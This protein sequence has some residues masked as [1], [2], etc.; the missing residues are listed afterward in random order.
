MKRI[1]AFVL[2]IIMVFS[3]MPVEAYAQNGETDQIAAEE[4]VF[5][6]EETQDELISIESQ[7]VP[8][9]EIQENSSEELQETLPENMEDGLPE[10]EQEIMPEEKQENVIEKTENYVENESTLAVSESG[11]C[12]ENAYWS[13]S[14]SGVLSIT[15]SG[16]MKDYSESSTAPWFSERLNIKR[17]EISDGITYVGDY[18]FYY[19]VNMKSVEIPGTVKTVGDYAFYKCTAL[20]IATVPEGVTELYAYVFNGCVSLSSVSLPPT[21]TYIGGYTFGGCVSLEDPTIPDSVKSMGSGVFSGCKKLKIM[22]LPESMTYLSDS[23]FNGC[24]S[25]EHVEIPDRVTAIGSSAFAGC[26]SLK[27]IDIPDGVTSI[28]GYAFENCTAL[29]EVNLPEGLSRINYGC[30]RGCTGLKEIEIPKG[31]VEIEEYA[32]Y[33]CSSLNKVTL[34]KGLVTIGNYAFEWCESLSEV[35]IPE[36]VVSIG[37]QCFAECYALESVSIPDTV[38]FLGYEIFCNCISLKSVNLTAG[39]TLLGQEMFEGCSALESISIPNTVTSF[40]TGT[41]SYCTSL[42][43]VNIPDKIT[44]IGANVFYECSAL[45]IIEIPDGVTSM[46]NGV[47]CGCSALKVIDIPGTVTSIGYDAFHDC[48]SLTEVTLPEGLTSI[49]AEL[50][51]GCDNLTKVQIPS[52]VTTIGEY[53]FGYCPKLTDITFNHTS[54]D[55]L[56]IHANAFYLSTYN[57]YDD[58]ATTI[59]VP[60]AR[61]IHSAIQNYEWDGYGRSEKFHSFGNAPAMKIKIDENHP[62]SVEAGLEVQFTATLEPKNTTSD[63][64]WEV[65]NV[66]GKAQ[67][68]QNGV[69]IGTTPGIVTVICKS[70]DNSAIY[71]DTQ[72]TILKATA[73]VSSIQVRC[74]GEFEAE[75]ELGDSVQMI[76]DVQPGNAMNKKIRW[77]IENGTGEA[78]ITDKGV[79]TGKSCGTVTVYAIAQDGSEVI[80]SRVVEVMRYVEEVKVELNGR[81]DFVQLGVAETAKMTCI[82]LPEDANYPKGEVYIENGT[83]ENGTGEATYY[84]GYLTGVAPGEVT[85]KVIAKDSH[86]CS[87]EKEIEIVGEKASYAVA[88]GYIYYNTETGTIIDCDEKVTSANIPAIINGT[89]ITGIAPQAFYS[90]DYLTSVTI[91]SSVTTIGDRAFYDCD[92]IASLRFNGSGVKLI[93]DYAFYDCDSLV[94]LTIPEGVETIG[95]CAFEY[96]SGL[97]NLTIPEGITS[98]E[99]YAF[100]G[101]NNLKNLTI[102]GDYNTEEWLGCDVLDTV[103]F[104]GTRIHESIVYDHGNGGYSWTVLPGR[105]AKKVIISD[106]VT[107]IGDHA[108]R[109]V[110]YIEEAVIGD[111]VK[112]IGEY[113]FSDCYE[114]MKVTMG[115][116]VETIGESAFWDCNSLTEIEIGNSVKSIGNEAFYRCENLTKVT[117]PEGI[118]T[119][120]ES[121]F[122]ECEKLESINLPS[123]LKSVGR[124]CFEFTSDKLQLIDLSMN[125]T[126]MSGQELK[127][128]YSMPKALITSAGQ[129]NE[130]WWDLRYTE[131]DMEAGKPHPW[132]IAGLD[133]KSGM[134]YAHGSRVGIV[135]VECR[136]EYTGA[137]GTW[138]IEFS[139]GITIRTDREENYLVSG[140]TMQLSAYIMPGNIK[141]NVRWSLRE[142]DKDYASIDSRTG[143][144]SARAVNGAKQIEVTAIPNDDSEPVS[145]ELWIVPKTTGLYIYEGTGDVTDQE[146]N[147][148]SSVFPVLEFTSVAYPEGALTEV[149]WRSSN[150][151]IASV[152]NGLVT[153][154]GLGTVTITVYAADG[155]GK[156]ASV[157]LNVTFRDMA[158]KLTA[159]LDVEST[160]LKAGDQAQML[161]Y[162]D[163]ADVPMDPAMFEYGI[164]TSQQSIATVD[165]D[166]VITAGEKAGTATITATMKDDP[167]GRKVSIKITV[168]ARLTEKLLLHPEEK[169]PAQIQM[170][171]ENGNVTLDASDVVSYSVLL[172]KADLNDGAYTFVITPEAFNSAGSFQPEKA[173]LKW[174]ST[175]TKVAT[176][177]AQKDGT[178]IVTIKQGVDGACM[179]SAVTT[180]KAKVENRLTVNV[181]D[182]SPRL[183]NLKPVLNTYLSK[184]VELQL[185]PSYENWIT[186]VELYENGVVSSRL[187]AVYEDGVVTISSKEVIPNS[188]IAPVLKVTCADG[189]TYDYKLAAKVKNT[190]PSV[191]VKQLDKMNLFYTDSEVPVK[192]TAADIAVTNV[193]LEGTEDFTVIEY[194]AD[195]AEAL[196][197]FSDS[198][199]FEHNVKPDTKAD[200]LV[201]LEGYEQ[202]VKKAITIA[203]TTKKPDVVLTEKSSVINTAMSSD[204]VTSFGFQLKNS[205]ELL[206]L[207]HAQPP[208][209]TAN[210]AESMVQEN[211]VVLRLTGTKGGTAT[212]ELQLDNWMS[213][214]KFSHKVT[215]DTKAPTLKFSASALKLSSVFTD[216][217]DSTASLLTHSN[218]EINRIDFVSTAKEG[219]AA[220][221]QS[222]KLR[223]AHDPDTNQIIARILDPED[224]PKNGSYVFEAVATLTDG[225]VLKAA[226]LKVTVDAAA[227]KVKLA[228][229]TLKLNKVLFGDEIASTKVSLDKPEGYKLI[230][231][232]LPDNW[233]EQSI[234]VEIDFAEDQLMVKLLDA[235]AAIKTHTIK[236]NPILIDESTGQEVVIPTAVSLRVQV[237][238]NE[239]IS[240]SLSSKGKLDVVDPNSEIRYTVSKINNASGPVT[241]VYLDGPDADLFD[242][243]FNENGTVSLKLVSGVDYSIKQT[244]K[245]QFVFSI[246]GVEV[247]S[248]VVSFKVTQSALKLNMTPAKC[249]LYQSQTTPLTLRV[250]LTDPETAT[251]ETITLG[252]KSSQEFVNALGADPM[253]VTIAEDGR[254]AIV[255]FDIRNAAN[256]QFGKSYVI[257]LDVTAVGSATDGKVNQMKVTINVAK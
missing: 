21:L 80:G 102:P 112:S 34:P 155:S 1:I 31:V 19:C 140:E 174:A 117:L 36:G 65:K 193:E 81:E 120:G 239:K 122:R 187:D 138:D 4:N 177:A 167:L 25:L 190:A 125:P 46:G 158:K 7:K 216:K 53:A 49:S 152:D 252:E 233:D 106:T 14:D 44:S 236:L 71:D 17:V 58:V 227:P 77:E 121:A 98:I 240:V 8:V 89:K 160:T 213:S 146:L 229:S 223:V 198:C 203:T 114:L 73:T 92:K 222:D 64:I 29:P 134:L 211:R 128:K 40:G 63:L 22:D 231:F 148:D 39:I 9:E 86:Q 76:A 3:V 83:D 209:V 159:A 201:Y 245:V 135:T 141:T 79:L 241:G 235:E 224:A 226:K 246:C 168:E 131:E 6:E 247:S 212:V 56:E 127:L 238:N 176:V 123:S 57:T 210:F 191:T 28:E 250:A 185:I 169:A 124:E 2:S 42:K 183:E 179:I 171:D 130:I 214:I 202:P 11:T 26:T 181:R 15:G 95:T 154:N 218:L 129:K 30:F 115:S 48:D 175:N 100:S 192:V 87:F 41:F 104:T 69:L 221:I 32:F 142:Q 119:I 70:S 194:D 50:L 144:L 75:V 182:F 139:S 107:E 206:D 143:K 253:D 105:R 90:R 18:A 255:E 13:L 242:Y 196:I 116:G 254:S 153:F 186:K 151:K 195:N 93:D 132:N 67:I 156:S 166:G 52:T 189:E 184:A 118:E 200:L 178:A 172:K 162:G 170:L 88:G 220:R 109:S 149:Y 45:E 251:M 16:K 150:E 62:A 147:I 43:T 54:E 61:D 66:T 55:T 244:Y 99:R 78:E 232:Q 243:C 145:I 113:A 161:V 10:E 180:D 38:T 35:K 72:I 101:V 51:R 37:Y 157:K 225:T 94:N 20:E 173:G 47:F 82:Y 84:N 68:D 197:R 85:I 228:A 110:G 199:S 165:A 248:S 133:S 97:K 163:N 91:P 12:G 207:T 60:Y 74:D 257:Y 204:Y 256:L 208:E 234:P 126:K 96:C 23:L 164:P 24:S 111:G 136:D 219:T 27:E 230:G 5:A 108:F 137:K 215:V 237:Y 217:V 188:N 103:T 249:T 33:G 205:I 59:R